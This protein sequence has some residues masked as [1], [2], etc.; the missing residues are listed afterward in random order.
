M[1]KRLKSPGYSDNNY[2]LWMVVALLLGLLI[3]SIVYR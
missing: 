2:R 3:L 1:S